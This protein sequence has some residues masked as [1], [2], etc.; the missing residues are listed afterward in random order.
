MTAKS[1]RFQLRKPWKQNDLIGS[2]FPIVEWDLTLP[3]HAESKS[4]ASPTFLRVGDSETVSFSGTD[5]SKCNTTTIPITYDG[6]ANL[7]GTINQQSKAL[8]VLVPTSITVHAGHKEMTASC[9]S[10]DNKKIQVKLSI[11]VL[12]E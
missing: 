2:D 9:T 1:I 6:V 8:D 4:S 10:S 11:D 5:W 3:E 7:A 12:K